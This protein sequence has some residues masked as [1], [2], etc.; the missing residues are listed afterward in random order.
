VLLN[1]DRGEGGKLHQERESTG[2]RTPE[3]LFQE[4][5]KG[6]L[7]PAPCR[8]MRTP[9]VCLRIDKRL[10]PYVGEKGGGRCRYGVIAL[11]FV[12]TA[13]TYRR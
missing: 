9:V 5:M 4:G 11:K 1:P 6:G 12:R 3:I 8:Y 13:F 10:T 2:H 7:V